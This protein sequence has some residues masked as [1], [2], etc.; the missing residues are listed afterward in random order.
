MNI[1]IHGVEKLLMEQKLDELKKKYQCSSEEDNLAIFYMSET[2]M[3]EVLQDANSVPFLSE[4]KMVIMKQPYFLTAKKQKTVSENDVSSFI[5]Y[6]SHDNPSTIFVI[7]LDEGRFDERKK[8]MKVL[9]KH[10]QFYEYDHVSFNQLYKSTREAVRSRG[11]QIEDDALTLLL[12]RVGD[13]LY[14]ISHQVDKLC[15]Y[16]KDIKVEDINKLVAAPLEEDVFALTNAILKHDLNKTM[17]IYKDLMVTN[18]EPIAL[19]GLIANSL[20][21][22]YQVKLLSRKGYQDKEIA[23]M[24]GLNPRAIYPIRKNGEGFDINELLE[25]LNALSEL[26]IKIKTGLIDKQRG[27]ELFLL[28]MES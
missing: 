9:R 3:I 6:I 20:R 25:K 28:N 19:I 8:V 5:E 14:E 13:D 17:M 27:L 12:N 1:V 10:A 11:C 21:N 16:T 15:L 26:D 4:Y 2:P 23:K 24:C 18:H 22:L 7:Y